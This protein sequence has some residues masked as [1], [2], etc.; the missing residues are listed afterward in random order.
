M[1]ERLFRLSESGTTV[2]TEILAGFTTFMT[3]AYIIVVQ[4][5]VLSG[6]MFGT[7]TGMDFGAVMTA[8]CVASAVTTSIMALYGRYPI[9]LA[10]GMGENFF[11]VFTIIPAASAAG[12]TVPWKT[13]LGVVFVS[14]VLFYLLYAI[15]IREMI[16][17]AISPSMK[18]GIAVGI[19]LFIAFIGLQ[20][21][22]LIVKN[23]GTLV[24]LAPSM[25][26]PDVAVFAVGLF[27]AAALHALRVRGSLLIGMAAATVLA[28][29]FRAIIPVVT[30]SKLVAQS[31][32]MTRFTPC[33]FPVSLPP[34]ITPT[35]FQMDIKHALSA[36]LVP[37]IVVLLFMDTFD[38]IGTL[39]GIAEQAGFMKDNRL[40]RV[41]QAMLADQ[42]GTVI[43]ACLG[44]STTTSYIESAAGVEAGGRTGLTALTVAIL[45]LLS[46]FLAPLVR[47]IGDYPPITAPA[48]VIV[49]AMMARNAAKV[50]WNDCSEAI[51]A[52]LVMLGIPLSYSIADGL[53]LGFVS[54]PVVKLLSG[55]GRS[56]SALMY[57]LA[58][59]LIVYFTLVRTRLP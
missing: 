37:I 52:F 28:L 56:V 16:F 18:N 51:P 9:A 17:N 15:G 31:M 41:R 6:K 20:S 3:M 22:G 34:S 40:P 21:A 8:T 39:I 46:L 43:G 38:T 19:G 4:P 54:Y 50:D 24:R 11:F 14:G 7:E 13:A 26:S 10:P 48:L 44:T 57:I 32:L 49:G 47:M 30:D 33:R 5:A 25:N 42:A 58:L 55:K 2:R 53:A 12:A 35:L 27:V 29:L 23:D 36:S 1:L 45:F 59:T